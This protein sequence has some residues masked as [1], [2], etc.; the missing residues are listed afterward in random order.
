MNPA[1]VPLIGNKI[2]KL[3]EQNYLISSSKKLIRNQEVQF[4]FFEILQSQSQNFGKSQSLFDCLDVSLD[5]ILDE[6]KVFVF[7]ENI[8]FENHLIKN[9]HLIKTNHF[10]WI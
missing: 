1:L 2:T 7:W 9:N 6:I 3:R 8:L 10:A 4:Y 5:L